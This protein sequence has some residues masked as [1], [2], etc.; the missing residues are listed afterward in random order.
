LIF[1]NGPF[2][3]ICVFIYLFTIIIKNVNPV[4]INPVK[5]I[6]GFRIFSGLI[7]LFLPIHILVSNHKVSN[8]WRYVFII[9][10]A[11]L[12][13]GIGY[14]IFRYY[15]VYKNPVMPAIHAVSPKT[16]IFLEIKKPLQTIK[17][18]NYQTDLWKELSN[19]QDISDFNQQLITL[20]SY[21]IQE[22]H[23]RNILERNSMI[24]ALQPNDSGKNK[25]LFIVELQ[26]PDESSSIDNFIRKVNGAKSI[27]MRKKYKNAELSMVNISGYEDLLNYSVYKG[28]FL[29]S[30]DESLVHKAIDQIDSKKPL[31]EDLFLWPPSISPFSNGA[32]HRGS[33]R[34]H[35]WPSP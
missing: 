32:R 19:I 23:M 13:A 35:R 9:F 8:Y 29:A 21:I 12:I 26:M 28:L 1:Y 22:D 14:F 30:F 31:E 6:S 10:I 15:E 4:I 17:K 24:L 34:R 7:I 16:P 27:L 20:N 18:L 2:L 3:P 11:L 25:I 5:F 33:M